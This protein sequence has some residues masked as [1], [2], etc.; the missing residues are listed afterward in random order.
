MDKWTVSNELTFWN[1]SL[2]HHG[3]GKVAGI[4]LQKKRHFLSRV[5]LSDLRHRDKNPTVV[6]PLSELF[7]ITITPLN[8]ERAQRM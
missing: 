3:V 4:F 6:A 7:T 1:R 2:M 5:F 8:R